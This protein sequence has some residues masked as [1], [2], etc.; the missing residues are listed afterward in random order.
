MKVKDTKERR[1]SR[2]NKTDDAHKNSQRL[3]HARGLHRSKSDGV[4]ALREDVGT[5]LHP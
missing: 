4:T 2:Y 3:V 5:S 1:P